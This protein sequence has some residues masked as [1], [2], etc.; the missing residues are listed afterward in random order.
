VAAELVLGVAVLGLLIYRQVVA[1]KLTASSLRISLILAVVG[2]FETAQF[3]Q[4]HHHSGGLTAAAL[5]GSL[6]LAVAFGAARAATVRIWQQDGSNWVQGTW[7]TGLLWAAALA[8]HLGYDFLLDAHHGTAGI[9]DATILLYLAVSLV[10]QR[11]ILLQ[12]ASRKFPQGPAASFYGTGP[13][14]GPA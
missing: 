2:V 11:L 4:K 7:V 6:V 1:R 3:L 8:A 5:A 12:R 10:A 9:G 14:T 13:G